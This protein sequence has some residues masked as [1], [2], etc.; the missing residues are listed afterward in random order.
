MDISGVLITCSVATVLLDTPM[1]R[2]FLARLGVY[3]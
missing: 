2:L 3:G 1:G